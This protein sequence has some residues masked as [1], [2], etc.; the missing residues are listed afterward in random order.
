MKKLLL[1]VVI[2]AFWFLY[3]YDKAIK[4]SPGAKAPDDPRQ[5]AV[6][7]AKPFVVDKYHITPLATFDVKAKVLSRKRYSRGR[8]ADLSPLDLA[9]GW[10]NMSD[11]A[12]LAS[13]EVT[14]SN[15]WYHW[16]TQNFPI[17]RREIET[18]SSNMHLIP[19]DQTTESN[20][21][22]ALQGEIVH[23]SGYL[24]RVD[25]DDG[26]HWVSSL[27]RKDKGGHA[28]EVVWVKDFE[29]VSVP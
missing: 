2:G 23:F 25:A 3:S 18:H 7:N 24:V 13:I 29:V 5:E 21:K 11:E 15:R 12:V 4:L 8:E 9:L 17:P 27:S 22:A 28:C 1:M 14:Q 10:G 26:W 19:A 20:M 6:R 16:R